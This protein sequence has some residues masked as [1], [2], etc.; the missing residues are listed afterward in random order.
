MIAD[1]HSTHAASVRRPERTVAV[2]DQ[3]TRRFAPGKGLGHL[4]CDPLGGRIG[5]HGDPD[6]P[7]SRVAK[8]HQTIEQLEGDGADHEQVN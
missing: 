4:A 1:T 2:T 6:Q 8:N 7:P 5:G 3:M